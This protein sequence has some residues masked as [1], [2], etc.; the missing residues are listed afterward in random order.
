MTTRR[1]NSESAK[2]KA[3]VT[4]EYD[5]GY[6]DGY[7]DGLR[8]CG[9]LAGITQFFKRSGKVKTLSEMKDSERR[10]LISDALEEYD[11]ERESARQRFVGNPRK[12]TRKPA[13][14]RRKNAAARPSAAS[15]VRR[16]LK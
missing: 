10:Q 12:R 8:E 6:R 16:A 1:R 2:A 14:K 11:V 4:S 5:S 3:K 7:L 9:P 13:K 15:L